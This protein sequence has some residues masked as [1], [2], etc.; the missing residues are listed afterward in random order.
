MYLIFLKTKGMAHNSFFFSDFASLNWAVSI[1]MKS[2]SII[3]A[4]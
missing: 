1:H 2:K 4:H 3:E